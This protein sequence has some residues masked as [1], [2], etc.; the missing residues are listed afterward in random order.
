MKN[1]V[2]LFLVGL[3]FLIVLFSCINI[4]NTE[5]FNENPNEINGDFN[6]FEAC[7]R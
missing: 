5:V 3:M 7:Q 4:N 2:P 6:A 1:K